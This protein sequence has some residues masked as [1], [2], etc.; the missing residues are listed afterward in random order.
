M[1]RARCAI[2]GRGV[3]RIPAKDEL[4]TADP[5]AVGPDAAGGL[6]KNPGPAILPLEK[7]LVWIDDI[8]MWLDW[9]LAA[10]ERWK[11]QE[12]IEATEACLITFAR[13]QNG[14]IGANIIDAL[15]ASYKLAPELD[16]LSARFNSAPKAWLRHWKQR[17][18]LI[19]SGGA[20]EELV[21]R[22]CRLVDERSVVVERARRH[23]EQSGRLRR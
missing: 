22:V 4:V 19:E 21:T 14:L 1:R 8:A 10:A 16:A 23:L 7:L 13:F 3:K 12:L 9:S 18:L 15:K 5:D 6:V 11:S 17:P 20:L 2:E